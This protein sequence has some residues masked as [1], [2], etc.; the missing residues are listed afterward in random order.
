MTDNDGTHL[1]QCRSYVKSTNSW[2]RSGSLPQARSSAGHTYDSAWGM[3][4]T[5]G[6]NEGGTIQDN[7]VTTADGSSFDNRAIP[8]YSRALRY[9]C[10][11]VIDENNLFMTGIDFARQQNELLAFQMTKGG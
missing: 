9:T 2:A 8:S 10:P 5:G 11:V 1:T 3:V 7:G 6:F 4:I